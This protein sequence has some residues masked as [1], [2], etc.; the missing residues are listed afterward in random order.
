MPDTSPPELLSLSDAARA[1]GVADGR[2]ARRLLAASGMPVLQ[3]GHSIRVRR[4]DVDI[5]LRRAERFT[6]GPVAPL[7]RAS[8]SQDPGNGCEP[9]GDELMGDVARSGRRQVVAKGVFIHHRSG[10]S[11]SWTEKNGNGCACPWKTQVKKPEGGYRPVLLVSRNKRDAISEK[12]KLQLATRTTRQLLGG[13]Q[14]FGE[15]FKE[16]FIKQKRFAS[17]TV[18]TYERTYDT[19]I[20]SRFGHI[21]LQDI[22]KEQVMAYAEWLCEEAERRIRVTSK[23]NQQ[24]I[25]GAFAPLGSA[26]THAVELERIER[27][28]AARVVLPGYPEA[29]RGDEEYGDPKKTLTASQLDC[30]FAAARDQATAWRGWRDELM[31]R[32]CFILGLRSG[33]LRALRIDDLDF[34]RLLVTV[35]RQACSKTHTERYV[36][37][38]RSRTLPMPAEFAL[39]LEEWVNE[40]LARG[41]T[42]ASYVF[43]AGDANRPG[44]MAAFFSASTMHCIMTGAM[45]RA[46]LYVEAG[47][48]QAPLITLH[49]LR[50]TC[51]S[52]L[53]CS[54]DPKVPLLAVSRFLGHAHLSTTETTYI[55]LL[56]PQAQLA[57]CAHILGNF[58]GQTSRR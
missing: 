51:A 21:P 46:G 57:T 52:Y 31:L 17:T 18:M 12:E 2:T 53:I 28:P 37:G 3:L 32:T 41:A 20:A 48:Q 16:V 30:L 5:V 29:Q 25:T 19:Y 26:L 1:F 40:L 47:G 7:P 44:A 13:T 8:L 56:E 4:Q 38:H 9:A 58:S 27:S 42:H 39:L 33:E 10:C 45:L 35:Q 15:F 22:R 49:G 24:F 50:H 54:T 11:K 36:K 34:V 14:S 55:H 23:R 6:P 43:D